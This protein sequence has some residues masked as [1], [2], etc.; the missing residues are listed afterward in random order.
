MIGFKNSG[1]LFIW[2]NYPSERYFVFELNVLTFSENLGQ[3]KKNY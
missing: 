3:K 1:I 2:G